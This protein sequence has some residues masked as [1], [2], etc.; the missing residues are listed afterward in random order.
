M[1]FDGLVTRNICKEFNEKLIYGKVD[2]I[3]QPRKD[4]VILFIRNNR[5]TYKL[6]LSINAENGRAH[7]TESSL[8]NKPEKPFNFCMV[9]RKHLMGG[10]LT[11]ISQVGNDRI[12]NFT[13]ENSNELGDKEIKTLIIEIMGK[14]SN[15]ILAT[16]NGTILDSAKHIDFE[17][18]SVR[19][20]MPGRTYI[21]PKTQE[22]LDPFLVKKE[23]FNEKL[24]ETKNLSKIFTGLSSKINNENL[25]TYNQFTNF[26]N[27]KISP[28]IF[29]EKSEHFDFYFTD[30][31]E[32]KSSMSFESLSLAI[33]TYYNKKLKEQELKNKKHC[34]LVGIL[35]LKEKIKKKLSIIDEKINSTKEMEDLRIKGEL[36][37]ANIYKIRPYQ[38]KIT[39]ENYYD[40]ST[41]TIKLD[42][43]L[44]PSQNVQKI[45][46]KYTKLKNTLTS[47]TKQ[48]QEL[49]NELEYIESVAFSINMQS[50]IEDLEEIEEEL[51]KGSLIKKQNSKKKTLIS[52]YLKFNYKGFNIFVGKNN[53]QNDNLTFTIARKGDIWFHVKNAPGSH[54]I[55][56]ATNEEISEDILEFSASLAAFYSKLKESPKV[57]ID[58]TEVK[59][60][61]K[62]PGQKPGMVTYTNYK[63]IYIEPNDGCSYL[64]Q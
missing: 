9:L 25:D 16:K 52:S 45:F 43:N 61:K 26:I 23:D 39:V 58:F 50:K 13:F 7:I 47:C 51:I 36:L 32:Y 10:K 18:S 41:I 22:K 64:L 4:E 60:V 8:F 55:L 38:E 28:V 46:K 56:K 1:P 15:I 27:R 63:T 6:L 2:K 19:E 59:N 30:L 24:K 31:K 11:N 62:I 17:I 20:I 54:T 53:I 40:N 29:T 57:E 37:S 44:S 34:L 33:D 42:K 3:I 12:I 35:S 48:S 5:T 49:N 14:H 21:L